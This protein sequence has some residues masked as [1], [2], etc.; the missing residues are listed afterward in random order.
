MTIPSPCFAHS[1]DAEVK[2]YV[3]GGWDVAICSSLFL[4]GV[5]CAQFAHY[6]G[7]NKR[8]SL[9]MKLFVAG[10]ALMT[11]LKSVQ[12][13]MWTQNVIFFENL[14]AASGLMY[15]HWVL[16]IS[17]MLGAINAFYVQM[18]FA[19]S[20]NS[21]LVVVCITLFTVG[22]ASAAATSFFTLNMARWRSAN[23][24]ADVYLGM[25]LGGDLLLTGSTALYLLRHSSELVLSRGPTASI[26]HS[27][28]RVTVQSAAPSA[29]CALIN[30]VVNM[31][32]Y[33]GKCILV[34]FPIFFITHMMFPHLYAWSAM[35]TLNLREQIQYRASEANT[36]TVDLGTCASTAPSTTEPKEYV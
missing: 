12:G 7:V 24:W 2:A 26:L 22:L 3:L 10:L 6:T 36:C 17:L 5:L 20:R 27:L 25:V 32:L 11:A 35:W 8:D 19:I 28:L 4:Q 29:L 14:E 15:T 16:E 13:I 34:L 33:T 23:R 30:F 31:R 21:Y 1:T 18:F 9:W